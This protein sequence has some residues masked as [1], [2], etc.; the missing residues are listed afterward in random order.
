MVTS[1]I[2]HNQT[3][4]LILVYFIVIAMWRCMCI[5]YFGWI[6]LI[7]WLEWKENMILG[8]KPCI[9][10]W[11]GS[12]KSKVWVSGVSFMILIAREW[13]ESRVTQKHRWVLPVLHYPSI[14]V[15]Y[16]YP[17]IGVIFM[18]IL[19]IFI[20]QNYPNFFSKY[21]PKFTIRVIYPFIFNLGEF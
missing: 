19:L 4:C 13:E 3:L 14:L 11:F 10:Y 1:Y 17:L 8:Y 16:H 2:P 20:I 5:T 6:S 15:V 7:F 18:I 9:T 21:Y 12:N